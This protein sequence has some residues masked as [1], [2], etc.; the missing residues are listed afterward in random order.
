MIKS[1][2]WPIATNTQ[3]VDGWIFYFTKGNRTK[4]P[5]STIFVLLRWGNFPRLILFILMKT[6][7]RILSYAKP[8]GWYAS[9]YGLYTPLHVIF[10]VL[11]L[12]ILIPVLKILFDQHEIT[13]VVLPEFQF[14][15][16]YLKQLFK[17]Y[18]EDQMVNHG[19][20]SAL[21]FVCVF[22]MISVL[23]SN[24]FRYLSA[25]ILEK[26]R[27]NVITNL[28]GEFYERMSKLDLNYFTDKKRGD[29]MARG[30]IDVQQVEV[31]VANTFTVLIRDPLMIVG[32]FIA[33]FIMSP[34]LTTYSL[35]VLPIAGGVISHLARRLKRRARNSQEIMG[36]I[37]NEL[38]ETLTGMR[39]IKAF[40]AEKHMKSKFIGEVIRY[41]QHIFKLAV[42][43]NLAQ[44]VAEVLG[45]GATCAIILVGGEMVLSGAVDSSVFIG[46]LVIFSQVLPPAKS[47]AGAFSNIQRGIASGERI[48]EVIDANYEIQEIKNAK[49]I[50]TLNEGLKFENVSFAYES[51]VVLKNISFDLPKGKIIALVGP[52]GAGKSTISDLIPRFFD[53]QEGLIS[54]DGVNLRD[55]KISS[56]R[57][58]IGVVTQESILFHDTIKNNITFGQEATQEEV[59][60]AAKNANAHEFIE[61]LE[62][63]YDALI[64]EHGSKLSG[65]QR[66]RLSIARALLNNPPILI[67]DEATSALDSESEQLVQEAIHN[68]M[69]NRT[70]LVV[71]HRLSTIQNADEILVLKEGGIIQRG[72]HET[73]MQKGGLYKKL[74]DMQSF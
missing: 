63:G 8:F 1:F 64:G 68:L 66:Q 27:I 10:G 60:A 16:S 13:Q 48:F 29:L 23:L 55:Y 59:I 65:G 9:Q 19:K 74:T 18:F 57:R 49:E 36:K 51:K 46:F 20:M 21:I 37:N 5:Q 50:G 73:L 70:T 17:Y 54:L 14:K 72:T 69:Q 26:F 3:P 7:L 28:R 61:E 71:A 12:V 42:K 32:L 34:K 62:Q 33:L 31:A 11:N 52:S 38:D 43:Q 39:V 2:E 56:L 35:L 30:T 67:L 58:M 53:P 45:I 47:F 4:A 15:L 6:Y 22:L 40:V 25:L 41:G 44:P 24:F